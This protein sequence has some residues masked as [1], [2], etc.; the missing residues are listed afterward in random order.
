MRRRAI[1][2]PVGSYHSAVVWMPLE[3]P[4]VPRAMA[5]RPRERGRLASV[6]PRR[7]SVR[8]PRW[9]STAATVRKSVLSGGRSAAGRSP[10]RSLCRVTGG[11]GAN[12][13]LLWARLSRATERMW[14]AVCWSWRGSV[15]RR[16]R[17]ASAED[18][19]ELMEVPPAMRPTERVVRGRSGRG[20][21][22]RS[23]RMRASRKMGLGEP[24]SL[25]E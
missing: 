15:E 18:G 25:Q 6:E 13:A 5:G 1:S 10:M 8:R 9:R 14:S 2:R 21:R 16:S 20:M 12:S 11:C 19:M 17:K 3:V 24:A 22:E 7:N 23:A 4:P